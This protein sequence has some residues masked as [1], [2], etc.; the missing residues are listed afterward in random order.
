MEA[1][2]T[3]PPVIE[4]D[5]PS[6][7]AQLQAASLTETHGQPA[8]R[9][10]RPDPTKGVHIVRPPN[11]FKRRQLTPRPGRL[12]S[13]LA[14]LALALVIAAPLPAAGDPALAQAR[15]VCRLQTASNGRAVCWCR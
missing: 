12:A 13:T 7:S 5:G 9:S 8:R 10:R 4:N 6:T 11:M 14:A 2:T 3:L 1:V 15:P